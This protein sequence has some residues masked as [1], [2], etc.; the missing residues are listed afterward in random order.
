MTRFLISLDQAVD[1]VFAAI[2][3]ARP[4]EIYVPRA[5]SATVRNIA[6]ALIGE[7]PIRIE[8]TGIRPG[9]KMHEIMVSDEEA[10]RAADREG[11]YAIRPMLPE[12]AAP[13]AGPAALDKEF[14]S[15]DTVLD[16]E[17]TVALL[18]QHRLMVED[19]DLDKG[20]EL[21]R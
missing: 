21:L 17:G 11:Y 9:E 7:R 10:I 18:R 2:A 5:P 16:L 3:G 20:G 19:V 6:A 8:V 15:G 12:L 4:G 14:S 1:T 13:D